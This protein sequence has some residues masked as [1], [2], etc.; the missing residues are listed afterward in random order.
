MQSSNPIEKITLIIYL[1]LNEIELFISFENLLDSSSPNENFT[2]FRHFVVVTSERP[3]G[4][5]D[6]VA[7]LQKK[8]VTSYDEEKISNV[9]SVSSSLRKTPRKFLSSSVITFQQYRASA[10]Y[11]KSNL[12][13]SSKTLA[14][15]HLYSKN[16]FKAT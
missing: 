5:N 13:F 8:Q 15:S 12:N 6:G 16:T 11:Y 9:T 14:N 7:A 10:G 3:D 2:L 4:Q 1:T